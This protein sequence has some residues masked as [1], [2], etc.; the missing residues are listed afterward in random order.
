METGASITAQADAALN[1]VVRG[2]YSKLDDKAPS[3]GATRVYLNTNDGAILELIPFAARKENFI[4]A[5][6]K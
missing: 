6:V 4:L 1:T 5:V 2:L 3:A